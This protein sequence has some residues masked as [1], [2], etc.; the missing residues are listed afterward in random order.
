[1]IGI[2]WQGW[3]WLTTIYVVAVLLALRTTAEGGLSKVL[4][5][6]IG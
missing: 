3:V 5:E 1:L 4:V 6:T 2:L